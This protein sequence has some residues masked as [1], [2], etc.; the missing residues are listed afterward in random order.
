MKPTTTEISAW[1]DKFGFLGSHSLIQRLV[2]LLWDDI[3][4]FILDNNFERVG[5]FVDVNLHNS[6]SP[7]Y[8]QVAEGVTNEEF[9]DLYKHR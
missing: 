2:L 1:I 9:V 8:Q 3:E 4:K 7:E 5:T 6:N